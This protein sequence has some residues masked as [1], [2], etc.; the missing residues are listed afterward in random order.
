MGWKKTS[1][2][3]LISGGIFLAFNAL[4]I[5]QDPGLWLSS[6][7]APMTDKF[8]PMGVGRRV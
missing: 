1:V 4:F 2:V 7:L 3:I 8:F 6:V 5:I